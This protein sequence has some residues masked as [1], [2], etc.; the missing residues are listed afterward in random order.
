MANI[1]RIRLPGGWVPGSTVLA[2]ELEA[3][4]AARPKVPNF[5]EGSSHAPT[6]PVYVGGQGIWVTGAFQADSAKI[7]VTT[8]KYILLNSGSFLTAALGSTTNLNGSVALNNTMTVGAIGTILLV[9]GASLNVQSTSSINL[10]NGTLTLSSGSAFN[11]LSGSS[12]SFGGAVEVKNGMTFTAA[13]FLNG[14]V[15]VVSGGSFT[16]QSGST[17]YIQ[18]SAVGHIQAFGQL[19]VDNA[20]AI[21]VA[22]GG[23]ITTQSGGGFDLYGR[24]DAYNNAIIY[25]R[26][27][28]LFTK[29][30]LT[31]RTGNSA[32]EEIRCTSLSLS[33]ST[34]DP[35]QSDVWEVPVAAASN[36][37]HTCAAPSPLPASGHTVKATLAKPNPS[38][39][40]ITFLSNNGETLATFGAL[41]GGAV[42]IYWSQ[43]RS[44]WCLA[45]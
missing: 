3:L 39:A 17:F 41:S 15:R 14:P 29:E 13:G 42:S 21:T 33:T 2:A 28:T 10:T 1:T 38:A 40:V 5:S 31:R 20:G 30:G 11:T 34:F 7:T 18:A 45:A 9:N 26:S 37:T 32:R 44:V 19:F 16:M 22:S 4:D 25:F 24:F 27:S 6:S 36:A 23:T 43:E 12:T 35:S 8:G